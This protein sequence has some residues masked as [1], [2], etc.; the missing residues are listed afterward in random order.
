[1]T[2]FRSYIVTVT[3]AANLAILG[4]VQLKGGVVTYM[5]VS[6]C[7]TTALSGFTAL[8]VSRCGLCLNM[9]HYVLGHRLDLTV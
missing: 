7:C 5:M 4:A 8:K 2:P 3:V 1:M 6:C 9:L